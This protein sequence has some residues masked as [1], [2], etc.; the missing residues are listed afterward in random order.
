[1]ATKRD[2][3]E[4]LE[5]GRDAS[6]ETLKRAYR[7]LAMQYH[8]DRNPGNTAAEMH[9]KEVSEAY[10]VLSDAQK[11]Q[12][13]DR[14]GHAAGGPFGGQGFESAF[15][16]FSDLFDAFFTGGGGGTRT[17][18]AARRGQDLRLDLRISFE[19]AVFGVTREVSIQRE[20]RCSVC[21]GDGGEPGTPAQTCAE[22]RGSGQ[23]R[24]AHQSFF[25]QIVN[26]VACPK[27]RGEG[28]IIAKP[29]RTCRGSGNV[30]VDKKLSVRIPSGVDE[31][32]QIRLSGEGE[33]GVR[34]GP[35]GDLYIVLEV[36]EHAHFKRHGQDILYELPLSV[37]QAALGDRVELPTIDGPIEL[38]VP[39][40]TQY[41]KVFRLAG[42]GV[43]H[44]RTQRRGDQLVIAR[45]VIPTDLTEAQK[46]A[47]R[48][49]G[50]VTGKPQPTSKGFFDKFRDA[51]G[52]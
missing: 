18:T 23:V 22:C 29:C 3:Y 4:V 48:E 41:G 26:I 44:V 36:K 33:P 35:S 13:Y 27:C 50:G 8:P 21:K 10:E 25:G 14:F 1:M 7:R 31:G 38:T 19:E 40:G 43:P 30:P 12:Q 32:S 37:A 28:R 47:L 42:K 17:R 49:L 52:M 39:A 11:R 15:G 6:P 51:I 9:F 34:G 46:R 16:G 45:V 20:E 2:Y 24:R 5:V